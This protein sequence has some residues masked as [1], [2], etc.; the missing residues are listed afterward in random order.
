MADET[1]APPTLKT[2]LHTLINNGFKLFASIFTITV[3]VFAGLGFLTI[4][5]CF[6][7]S[8][9]LWGSFCVIIFWTKQEKLPSH[10]IVRFLE[11]QEEGDAIIAHRG[12]ADEAPE[13][14]L[15]AFE[16][17]CQCTSIR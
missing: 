16:E 14:T 5:S 2:V 7:L 13:N 9:F 15:A 1:S 6:V 17:V 8:V 3:F 11:N 12:G 10:R 4:Y